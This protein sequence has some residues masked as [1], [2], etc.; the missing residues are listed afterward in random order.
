MQMPCLRCGCNRWLGEDW[1]ARCARCSWTCETQGY[2]N[3]SRPLP[4]FRARWVSV[5]N[6]RYPCLVA[7]AIM[8]CFFTANVASHVGSSESS[9]SWQ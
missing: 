4:R 1:D 5:A 8:P 7:G 9:A 3:E 2:D 6:D